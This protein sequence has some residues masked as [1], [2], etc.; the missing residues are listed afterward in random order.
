MAGMHEGYLQ[1]ESEDVDDLD[2][3]GFFLCER[4]NSSV[5]ARKR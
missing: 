2:V 1:L 4:D 3:L 5:I